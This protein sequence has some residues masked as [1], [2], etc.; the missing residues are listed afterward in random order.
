MAEQKAKSPASATAGTVQPV[1]EA[2]LEQLL[3]EIPLH[4][5]QIISSLF[6]QPQ[7]GNLDFPQ[8]IRVYC[9]HEKCG[10]VRRH[11]KYGSEKSLQ[12]GNTFFHFVAYLCTNCKSF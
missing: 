6:S 11:E 12:I 3:C 7:F 2:T 9:D 8:E 4:A 5:S 1:K 10:G